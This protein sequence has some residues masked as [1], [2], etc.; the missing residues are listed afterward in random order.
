MFPG[1]AQDGQKLRE[2]IQEENLAFNMK[3]EKPYYV[4]LSVGYHVIRCGGDLII[5]EVFKDAD[6]D[7]YEEKKKRRKSVKK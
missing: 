1:N 6:Q 4:E 5:S 3:S 2:R 7:L